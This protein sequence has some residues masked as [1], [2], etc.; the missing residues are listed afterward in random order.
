[1][2]RMF[3]VLLI[4]LVCGVSAFSSV[5]LELQGW[6]DYNQTITTNYPNYPVEDGGAFQISRFYVTVQG[7]IG[8]DWF[9]N[10][11]KARFTFD[12]AK[13]QFNKVSAATT[14]TTKTT[15]STNSDG[16]IKTNAASTS[17]STTALTP[18]PVATPIKFAYIDYAFLTALGLKNEVVFSGGLIK[19]YF[20]NIAD[21]QYPIPVKDATEMYGN[22]KPS[23]S[24]DYGFMFSGK[25]LSTDDNPNG[26]VKY[27]LEVLNGE[28]YDTLVVD[29]SDNQANNLALQGAAYIMPIQGVS[30]G[31]TYRMNPVV[32]ML[33]SSVTNTT[34]NTQASY[35][36]L[37]AAKNIAIGDLKIPVDFL[38]QYIGENQSVSLRNADNSVASTNN[39]WNGSVVS[40]MLGYGLLDNT[41]TPY[42]RYDIVNENDQAQA[43]NVS[44]A[45]AVK[46]SNLFLGLNISPTPNLQIKPFYEVTMA[47]GAKND[48]YINFYVQ[49]DYKINF[50]IWQ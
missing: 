22:V 21:W 18:V 26:L 15:V 35:D 33:S 48:G 32:K 30:V 24:A 27:Y 40:V 5:T 25:F 47:P 36:I 16:T 46:Y 14:T 39:V 17:T 37:L 45:T 8:K 44:S 1:M 50:T 6:A 42:I 9:G 13:D 3:L 49:L 29:A 19:S 10:G 41:V 4:C 23:A 12:L 7:D 11:L 43:T 38:F 31:A 2:K 34:T 20:G 28:G